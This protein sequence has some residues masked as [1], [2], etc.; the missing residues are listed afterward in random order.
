ME[1]NYSPSPILFAILGLM[2]GLIMLNSQNN[3]EK[4]EQVTQQIVADSETYYG[5]TVI[6]EDYDQAVESLNKIIE[7]N[8]GEII[9]E[10]NEDTPGWDKPLREKTLKVEIPKNNYSEFIKDF[11]GLAG[12]GK[13][14]NIRTD[15]EN[16]IL[17]DNKKEITI[18]IEEKIDVSKI[19]DKLI[20][21]AA[22]SFSLL[23]LLS[24]IFLM[25]KDRL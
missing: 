4:T 22:F 11:K 13:S 10:K 18:F 8:K 15:Q 1:R 23:I 21:V 12:D 17:D 25:T 20:K 5:V 16:R 14:F 24:I 19:T 9:T 7:D 6:E 3:L 2:I